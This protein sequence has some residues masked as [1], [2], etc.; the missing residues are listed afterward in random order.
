MILQSGNPPRF[1]IR[2]NDDIDDLTT[3]SGLARAAQGRVRKIIVG[4]LRKPVFPSRPT[5]LAPAR[6]DRFELVASS[7]ALRASAPTAITSSPSCCTLRLLRSR[8]LSPSAFSS[9][10]KSRGLRII[11]SVSVDGEMIFEHSAQCCKIIRTAWDAVVPPEN[12]SR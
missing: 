9:A 3:T 10:S 5:A 6:A 8:A 12:F 4:P 2:A 7:L 1:R 11:V